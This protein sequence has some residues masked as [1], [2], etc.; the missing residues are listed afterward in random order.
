M[1]GVFLRNGFVEINIIVDENIIAVGRVG[2]TV[3]AV[4]QRC[5]SKQFLKLLKAPDGKRESMVQRIV[6]QIKESGLDASITIATSVIAKR[7]DNQSVGES[8]RCR[9]RA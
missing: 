3:V 5:R 1:H 6:R 8:C 9:N 7:C 4:V 2:E